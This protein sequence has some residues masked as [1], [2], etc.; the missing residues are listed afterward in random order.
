MQRSFF[1]LLIVFFFSQ[2][3]FADT[4]TSR[5]RISLLT[6]SPGEP[7]YATFGHTAIRIIDSARGSDI[8]YNYGTFNFDD[9]GFYLKFVRGKLN[10]Y[11]SAEYFA[12]FADAYRAE[13][14]SITEQL[15]Q[16]NAGE[17]IRLQQALELNRLPDNAYYR[18]DFFFDNCT[19]RAR[20]MLL[21]YKDSVPPLKATMPPG[22]RFRQALHRYLDRNHKDWSRLSIDLLLGAPTDAV[23][24]S[25]QMQFLPDN[26]MGALDS[27]N[28]NPILVA[29]KRQL[30][31]I[32][33]ARSAKPIFTPMLVFSLILGLMIALSFSRNGFF[34]RLLQ[35]FDG[36]LFFLTGLLGVILTLMWT[37]TDHAMCRNNY[38]LLWAWPTHVVMAFLY[39]RR[40]R[41]IRL[42]FG[43]TALVQVLVLMS[44][45]FLPQQMNT[46]LL[47][48]V[49]LLA[50]RAAAHWKRK[51]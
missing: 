16:L 14:R 12:D 7:L 40:R 28:A 38:N 30:Y 25:A 35:G 11:L 42:Y 1:S 20:D 34:I 6:C 3:V 43:I 29:A 36:M 13:D 44:W 8:V 39:T 22:T 41:W 32:P 21:K 24:S 33:V 15:L 9:E 47:P 19:T 4:D 17:K 5:L 51:S 26:L 18:Y 46:A 10:Y 48:V 31:D 49:V 50:W 37:A 27:S 45:G 23:M 2:P